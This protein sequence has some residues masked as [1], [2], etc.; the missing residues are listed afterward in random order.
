M[1]IS[2][3]ARHC[4]LDP[5]IRLYIEQRFAR[6]GKFARDIQEAHLVVTAEKFRHVAE[7]TL[8]LKKKEMVSREHSTEPRLAID[9]AADRLEQQLRRLKE[10]RV[11]RKR[12]AASM[13]GLGTVEP[14]GQGEADGASDRDFDGED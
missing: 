9:L 6:L 13:N 5:E 12:H 3:T 11:D 7:I 4:E 2:T 14:A 10:R 8:K 1:Q